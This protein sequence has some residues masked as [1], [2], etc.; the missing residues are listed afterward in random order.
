MLTELVERKVGRNLTTIEADASGLVVRKQFSGEPDDAERRFRNSLRWD[1]VR[2]A[3]APDL[4]PPIL[5]VDE[6]TRTVTFPY[7][8][9]AQSLQELLDTAHDPSDVLV[10]FRKAGQLLGTLH[11]LLPEDVGPARAPDDL[12][13]APVS[14]FDWITAEGFA[15]ASGGELECWRLLQH[16]PELCET[17]RHWVASQR[18]AEV[19][20]AHG[21]VRPDQLL[22]DPAGGMLLVDW[23][24]FT[25]APPQRDLCG[26]LGAVFFDALTRTFASLDGGRASAL[27]THQ[28]LLERGEQL[29]DGAR[30]VIDAT[31]E[32]YTSTSDVTPSPVDLA[33]GTGWYV[34]DR[35]IARSMMSFAMS[36][37]D[38]GLAGIGRQ[39]VIDPESATQMFEGAAR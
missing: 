21:D 39:L 20:P 30:P 9:D 31:I 1:A 14:A 12:A 34:L 11:A 22:V 23:E 38:R 3:A 13:A 36:P 26:L 5:D 35:V 17:I 4:A 16:D 10:E 7:L 37:V 19:R 32:G 28:L 25:L 15:R 6:T 2:A 8:V 27:E 24:E 33:R 29:I 18:D